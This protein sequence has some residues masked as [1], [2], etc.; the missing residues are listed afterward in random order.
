VAV[1]LR[2]TRQLN[3]C[4]ASHPV[5]YA[6]TEGP[7]TPTCDAIQAA[8]CRAGGRQETRHTAQRGA[9]RDTG[10]YARPPSAADCSAER[11]CC[12]NIPPVSCRSGGGTAL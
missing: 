6:A 1:T 10:N 5:A 3:S 7:R 8:G 9:I 12:A 11:V 2:L 4:L